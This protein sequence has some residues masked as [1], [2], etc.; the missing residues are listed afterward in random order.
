MIQRPN[1]RTV[2]L[3]LY[4]WA[5]YLLTRL[6]ADFSSFTGYPTM[7]LA[8]MLNG[9]AVRPFVSR[10]LVPILIRW[11]TAHT[12][13]FF[14]YQVMLACTSRGFATEFYVH[15]YTFEKAVL[16]TLTFLFYLGTALV[17]R[18]LARRYY[19]LSS[20]AAWLAGL[21]SLAF[22]PLLFSAY[23]HLYDPPTIFFSSAMLL[24]CVAGSDAGFGIL[25]LVASINRETA[26]LYLPVYLVFCALRIRKL[27][28][29][30]VAAL[31]R[32][33]FPLLFSAALAAG[34]FVIRYRINQRY[35]HNRGGVLDF[36]LLDHNL[37]L[38]SVAPL[39][40]AWSLF[41]GLIIAIFVASQWRSKPRELR[42]SLILLLVP[43]AIGSL[44]YGY[45]EELRVYF[46]LYPLLFLL[47]LPSM[48]KALGVAEPRA[49]P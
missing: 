47:A 46:E 10:A 36:H 28:G 20:N 27:N 26:V 32:A 7:S 15:G 43:L 2:W 24:A 21:A 1:P 4:L 19:G 42:W 8:A 44:I 33:I 9:T 14:Q 49:L 22:I 31:R 29:A 38:F 5:S 11:I 23:S 41:I 35:A 18:S 6:Y 40:G 12:S 25:L 37:R 16:L 17:M 3:L 39:A 30:R 45:V 48:T 34:W 13:D